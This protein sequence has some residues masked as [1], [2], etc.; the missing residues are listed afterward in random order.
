MRHIHLCLG[1]MNTLTEVIKL[2]EGLLNTNIDFT[3]KEWEMLVDNEFMKREGDDGMM[4][5]LVKL[6]GV[7]SRARSQSDDPETLIVEVKEVRETLN[8]MV[9]M[10][11]ARLHEFESST[12]SSTRESIMMEWQ[13]AAFQC[14]YGIGMVVA[15]ICDC[16][17]SALEPKNTEVLDELEH[18]GKEILDLAEKASKY[19]PLGANYMA[20]CLGAAW[21]GTS[22][23]QMKVSIEKAWIKHGGDFAGGLDVMPV[24]EMEWTSRQLRLLDLD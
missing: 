12:T 14:A 19:K 15:V 5:S 18:Y 3:Q 4:S 22:D 1:Y 13:D 9:K 24:G 2:F 11:F 21:V 7:F 6:R 17:L 16:I 23:P 20:L 8:K 10:Q